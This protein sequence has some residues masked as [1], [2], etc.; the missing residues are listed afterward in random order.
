HP[1]MLYELGRAAAL[2]WLVESVSERTQL[3]IDLIVEQPPTVEP[4]PEISALLFSAVRELLH[5][6]SKHASAK[7]VQ[8]MLGQLEDRTSITV[9]DDGKGFH[10]SHFQQKARENEGFGLFSIRTRL[11]YVGGEMKITSTPGTGTRVTLIA[12]AH[13]GGAKI[14]EGHH[15]N[16]IGG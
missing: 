9:I 16:L 14:Q 12:P 11:I 13:G 2:Q 8:V 15:E 4:A 3:K 10:H 7:N 6:V 1:P 5:N